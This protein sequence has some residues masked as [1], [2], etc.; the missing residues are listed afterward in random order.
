MTY[1]RF[2]LIALFI[3]GLVTY[4]LAYQLRFDFN[5][6]PYWSNTP[7]R[8]APYVAILKIMLFYLL[9]LHRTNWRYVGL[10]DLSWIGLYSLVWTSL[11]YSANFFGVNYSNPR[12][13][14]VLDGVL[15]FIATCG[16]RVAGRYTREFFIL[17]P[18]NGARS[19]IRKAVIIGAG[20]AGEMILRDLNRNVGAGLKVLALFDDNPEKHGM[21]IHGIK[22]VGA[23]DQIRTYIQNQQVQVVIIAIPSANRRQMRLIYDTLEDLDVVIKTLPSVREILANSAWVNQLR[24]I[25][26]TDLLGREEIEIDAQSISEL[27]QGKSVVVTGAAGSIGSELCHQI[28]RRYPRILVMVDKTE[29]SLFHA[30][31]KLLEKFSN[32][33][34]PNLAPVL[35]DVRD[36]KL[37]K[38]S[39]GRHKPDIVFHA[40]AHKHVA[41]Q[42]SNPLEC[43]KNNVGGI[44]TV[45]RICHN[46]G[47]DRFVLISTDKAVNPTS[48]MGATKRACE[49]YCQAYAT[50]SGTKFMAVRFGNVLAS[51]GSVAPLFIEQIEKGGPVK[52]TH[53]QVER[54]FMSIPEAVTLVLQAA[55]I[56]ESGQLL[57]L[58]MGKP[59]KIIDLARTLIKLSGKSEYEIGIEFTG[60][61]PGE[62]LTEELS[63]SSDF[64]LPTSNERIKI[65]RGSCHDPQMTINKIDDW[66]KKASEGARFDVRSA[67]QDIAPEYAPK[68]TQPP[69]TLPDLRE[70]IN[71]NRALSN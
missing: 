54:Y 46:L 38:S 58:D 8:F 31:R 34:S 39:L 11:L 71:E 59:I 47:V 50:M 2:Q 68:W 36:Y 48:V 25:N 65:F 3:S 49:L 62:K 5:V 32:G 21:T 64:C 15:T 53:P 20:D 51:E 18:T 37:L 24:E 70:E 30:H 42:E 10:R 69:V 9:G 43:F 22:V 41:L 45:T 61:K 17:R 23:M 66:V 35:C 26:I 6:D 27:I 55:A 63:F 12:G 28:I 67:L 7:W 57:M 33:R 1:N 29:N 40:A 16:I 60:L 14:I 13:V 4:W 52:V 19:K 44:Q 56:G